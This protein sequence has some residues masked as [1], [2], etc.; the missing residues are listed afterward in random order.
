MAELSSKEIAALKANAQVLTASL[1]V[2][3]AGLSAG[4]IEETRALLEREPLVKIKLL[5]AALDS[6]DKRAIAEKLAAETGAV[7]VEVRGFTVVLFKRKRRGR[8]T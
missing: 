7:L 8:A 1:Q 5:K 6:E 2:G 4:F 3:K